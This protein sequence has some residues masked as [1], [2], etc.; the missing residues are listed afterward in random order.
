MPVDLDAIAAR[1]PA[2]ST[3]LM[4]NPRASWRTLALR[5]FLLSLAAH[6]A[7]VAFAQAPHHA[8]HDHDDHA[9]QMDA[10]GMVMNSNTENLPQDCASVSDDVSIDVQVGREFARTGLTY[11]FSA[12]VWRVPP[13][14]RLRVT[15]RNLDEVRHQWMVHGLPKYLYPQGM[16]HLE[17]N[18]RREVTGTFIVPSDDG[19]YL[20]HCDVS[21]HME[22]GLKA[23][24]LVGR[25]AGDLP[26]IPGV[27]A[28]RRPDS[29]E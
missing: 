6:F 16:F 29:Y 13:C 12:H 14:A 28:Q 24:L 1:I 20:V 15:L 21:H 2:Q 8:H 17:A 9:M 22:Q 10:N 19:T 3:G 18:G 27:S 5:I 4:L 26:S 23:Q 25:G 11:G 7:S